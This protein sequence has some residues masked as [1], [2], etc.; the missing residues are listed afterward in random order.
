[1]EI[2][3]SYE[4]WKRNSISLNSQNNLILEEKIIPDYMAYSKDVLYGKS[5]NGKNE[6][7]VS[8]NKNLTAKQD[9]RSDIWTIEFDG[10]KAENVGSS[11]K[12][13]FKLSP[14]KALY[15]VYIKSPWYIY[16]DLDSLKFHEKLDKTKVFIQT[17]DGYKAKEVDEDDGKIVFGTYSATISDPL[18]YCT[19]GKREVK[20]K[21][22]K[23]P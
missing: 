21:T 1:M 8:I 20:I 22:L 12:R 13:S 5:Q 14:V 23:I 3:L 7:Y 15:Y 11:S 6:Y 2:L 19:G 10:I 18:I 17:K 16:S 4:S 9:D